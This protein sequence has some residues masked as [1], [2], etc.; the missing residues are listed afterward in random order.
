[1]MWAKISSVFDNVKPKYDD[2]VVDRINYF[3]TPFAIATVALTIALKQHVGEPLQCWIPKQFTGAWEKFSE[4]YCFVENTYYAPVDGRVPTDPLE[5]QSN[6]LIYY[7]WVP[8]ILFAL[9]FLFLFPRKL[10]SSLNWK[11]GYHL[12]SLVAKCQASMKKNEMNAKEVGEVQK[13]LWEAIGTRNFLKKHKKQTNHLS[14]FRAGRAY[15]SSYLTIIYVGYKSLNVFN[16]FLQIYLLNS[17]LGT[18][19][20]FWGFGVLQDLLEGRGWR[21]SGAFPRV[22]FCDVPFRSLGNEN[23]PRSSGVGYTLQCVLP[24][25]MFNEKIFILLWIWLAVL[26]VLNT[27]NLF[28]WIFVM[29]CDWCSLEFLRSHLAYRVDHTKDGHVPNNAALYYFF[30]NTLHRDG[31]LVLRLLADNCGDIVTSDLIFYLWKMNEQTAKESLSLSD[32]RHYSPMTASTVSTVLQD[33]LSERR[34][35]PF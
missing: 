3:Y 28:Y 34:D 14:F 31:L 21:Q 23:V 9:I 13:Q 20:R 15:Y 29:F 11:S 1:M 30:K 6:E 8:F 18:E 17:F 16:T 7:Q 35:K 4:N 10:W 26:A 2:D 22:V 25:N 33:D 5:R 32:G 27:L 24:I 12:S 19:Y